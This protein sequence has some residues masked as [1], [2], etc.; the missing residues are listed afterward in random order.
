[1]SWVPLVAGSIGSVLGGV[2]ADRILKLF[3][4]AARVWVLVIGQ[5]IAAPLAL[6]VLLAAVP[7]IPCLLLVDRSI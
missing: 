5:A 3:G 6:S 1:M 7:F 2:L 4:S